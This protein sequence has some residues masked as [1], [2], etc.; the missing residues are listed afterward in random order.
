M[1]RALFSMLIL[2]LVGSLAVGFVHYTQSSYGTD[3]KDG[4]STFVE[5]TQTG[6]TWPW[7]AFDALTSRTS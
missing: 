4:V 7:L 6:L 2:Y 5:A 1:N 3:G